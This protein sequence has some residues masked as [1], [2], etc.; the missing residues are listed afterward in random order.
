M[1]KNKYKIGD[2][3]ETRVEKI[4]PNGLGMCF[5]ENLTVFVPLSAGGDRLRV[6][7]ADIKGKVAFA[8]ILE[9]LEPSPNR[10]EPPCEYYGKCGG[11]D[12]QHISYEEQLT[13]KVA[14][15]RD[16]LERIG[17]IQ[18]EDEIDIVPSPEQ[19]GYRLRAQWHADTRK[20]RI[21]YFKRQSHEVVET[22]TC[23]ILVPELE[24]TMDRLRN[25]VPW[26]TYF[27]ENINIEAAADGGGET[28]VYSEELLE[29]TSELRVE[30]AQENFH[31][32]ARSFFQG[33]RYL[34]Q[35]LVDAATDG[36]SGTTALDLYCG[37]G[38]FTVS[39]GKRFEKVV[40]V[41]ANDVSIEFA[42]KNVELAGLQNVELIEGR[43]KQFLSEASEELE[44]V[45]FLVLD[46][47]RSGVKKPTL[48]KIANLSADQI[49]YVSCNPSTLSRDLGVLNKSGYQIERILALDLFPQTHHVETVVHLKRK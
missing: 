16:C 36:A 4:V 20:G 22:E 26:S 48:E 18:F 13:S 39:L 42:Q 38:L 45:D 19:F 44:S 49:S 43:V 28:S 24:E 46:P 31:F 33:N 14:I 11:C 21:G 25:D 2:T 6:E 35:K 34:L 12:F 37:V 7:I 15:L 8:R 23:S 29:K 10:V 1:S 32:N 47:P 41:E 27:S 3:F 17:K 40:G 9:I 5:A 30:V